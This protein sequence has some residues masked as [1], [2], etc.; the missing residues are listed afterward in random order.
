LD[1]TRVD[2]EL[3]AFQLAAL[4]G[5]TRA[6]VE[7]HL[8]GCARC[9]SAF[10]ALKR[11]IDAA[12]DAMAPSEMLRARIRREAQEQL[13]A[14]SSQLSA[15]ERTKPER[16][17]AEGKRVARPAMWVMA[18]TAAALLLAAPFAWRM[19]RETP[20]PTGAATGARSGS[21]DSVEQPLLPTKQ[22]VD[23]ARATPENL[24]FL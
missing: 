7:T 16:T 18:A 20:Q 12:E 2:E 10:L 22:T 3:I 8:T 23:T 5:A 1:C 9:V 11:A 19:A 17:D 14:V 4:D 15:T 24:A 13:S 21:D 6:A